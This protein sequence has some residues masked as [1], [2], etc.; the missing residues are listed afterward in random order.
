M[1]DRFDT[2]GKLFTERVRKDHV[3]VKIV[4]TTGRV[5]GY[6]HVLQNQRIK[7]LLNT[8]NEQFLAVTDATMGDE[9]NSESLRHDFI[10]INKQYILTV[11]PINDNQSPRSDDEYGGY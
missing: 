10:T 2:K 9:S 3:E 1:I 8:P 7:D 4:T 6:V 5:H 11:I